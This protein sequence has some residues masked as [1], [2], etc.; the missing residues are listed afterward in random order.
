MVVAKTGV[1]ML[2]NSREAGSPE[3]FFFGA[4][5]GPKL[6]GCYHESQRLPSG[7][8]PIVGVL[9]C[10]PF[11]FEEVAGHRGIRQLAIDCATEGFPCLR[12]DYLGCGNSQLDERDGDQIVHWLES[13]DLAASALKEMSGVQKIVL[14]GFRLGAALA[15]LASVERLDIFGLI[16][17]SP[18]VKG[19]R[20]LRELRLQSASRGENTRA[21][22]TGIVLEPNG[23][24]LTAIT[25]NAIERIDLLRETV[26]ARNILIIDAPGESTDSEPW[27]E[28]LLAQG[29]E[30][31]QTTIHGYDQLID[32]PQTSVVPLKLFASITGALANWTHKVADSSAY[33][34]HKAEDHSERS[35]SSLLR[36]IRSHKVCGP[37]R[38]ANSVVC[39]HEFAGEKQE[40]A[41]KIS[42]TIVSI[43]TDLSNGFAVMSEPV[44]RKVFHNIILLNSGQ[45]RNIGP[46]RFW[47][48]L[49]RAWAARGFRVLRLDLSG[50]GESP[51]LEDTQ[52]NVSYASSGVRE[53]AAAEQYLRAL[54]NTEVHL[55][56]LCSGGYQALRSAIEGLPISSA[57]L[58]N[59]LAFD[60]DDLVDESEESIANYEVL[61]LSQRYREEVVT[62]AFW[63]KLLHGRLDLRTI[64]KV[65]QRRVRFSFQLNVQKLLRVLSPRLGSNIESDLESVVER[66]VLLNLVFAEG[67]PGYKLLRRKIGRKL[68]KMLCHRGFQI[69]HIPSADHTFTQFGSRRR[70]LDSLNQFSFLVEGNQRGNPEVKV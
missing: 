58:I 37:T 55:V 12:F 1:D 29:A 66:G 41:G 34:L 27:A 16:A 64:R 68:D 20:Y 47:V 9:I 46:N 35:S 62:K 67:D 8:S 21:A 24:P 18:V 28:Q 17:V 53:I 59:P 69:V 61:N 6:F 42:E 45:V 40:C 60:K 13:I 15:A 63:N 49:S 48:E 14:V 26:L 31:E 54:D 2:M 70:L 3:M 43:P 4:D 30:I 65:A 22:A 52:P 57:T 33:P 7:D 56:G 38:A 23:F 10:N 25:Y 51:A 44:S 11:G 5:E 19:R 36:I 39:A 32:D 50:I